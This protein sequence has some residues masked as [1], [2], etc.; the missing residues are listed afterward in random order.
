MHQSAELGICI[1]D[2]QA[3]APLRLQGYFTHDAF[4]PAAP[5]RFCSRN[6]LEDIEHLFFDC[7]VAMQFMCNFPDQGCADARR[8]VGSNL[9]DVWS[10]TRWAR[11]SGELRIHIHM[12]IH[13]PPA[14]KVQGAVSTAP[15]TSRRYLCLHAPMVGPPVLRCR[16]LLRCQPALFACHRHGQCR[17]EAAAPERH[18][19]R[20]NCAATTRQPPGM[21]ARCLLPVGCRPAG[22]RA[23]GP[24]WTLVK[25]CEGKISIYICIYMY[26]YI[27]IYIYIYICICKY[28][29]VSLFFFPALIA[30]FDFGIPVALP[31]AAFEPKHLKLQA[32]LVRQSY[33]RA[34]NV[35]IALRADA[36]RGKAIQ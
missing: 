12:H 25:R 18:P 23:Q 16:A 4:G 19:H 10:V 11:A 17:W 32:R 1:S 35:A 5:C 21:T 22:A 8:S 31:T 2:A 29:F 26:M 7:D 14:R 24:H 15:F 36:M 3:W 30:N 34:L 28:I 33:G 20:L 27:Y 13:I 9:D 6:L